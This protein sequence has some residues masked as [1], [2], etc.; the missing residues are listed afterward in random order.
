MKRKNS[1]II[2]LS[3]L[4]S[5]LFASAGLEAGNPVI[6]NGESIDPDRIIRM[7]DQGTKL[8]LYNCTICGK[9][10][11]G[12]TVREEIKFDKCK[13]ADSVIVKGTY[14][15]AR[16]FLQWSE[17][18]YHVDMSKAIFF[19][20]LWVNNCSF[21]GGLNLRDAVLKSISL[22]ES[23]TFGK[24]FS[25]LGLKDATFVLYH[26]QLDLTGSIIEDMSFIDMD[27]SGTVFEPRNVNDNTKSFLAS[28]KGLSNLIYRYD[29]KALAQLKK[30]FKENYF[31]QQEREITCAIKRHDQNT[32]KRILLDLPF[33]YGASIW[34]PLTI[35]LTLCVICAI[36]Y[37]LMFLFCESHGA[38]RK[39]TFMRENSAF[40]G[41]YDE[42]IR[43]SRIEIIRGI[44]D[45]NL[46]LRVYTKLKSYL[47]IFG[48]ALLLSFMSGTNIS[49]KSFDFGRWLRL[50]LPKRIDIETFGL[51]RTISG[52]QTVFSFIIIVLGIALYFGRFFD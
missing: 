45:E 7:I 9:L 36:V 27:L 49:F 31:R 29:P 34:R 6:I 18:K 47:G 42:N 51:M 48:E 26:A 37:F 5:F 32:F 13:F 24:G 12:D 10:I 23:T 44:V 28:C 14:L 50:M 16:M 33:E 11:F 40:E 15:K 17:F 1:L 3:L 2:Y 20:G 43:I 35:V 39:E 46:I 19:K 30:H 25:R 52:I 22:L 38:Y 41:V 4:L 21:V 8:E